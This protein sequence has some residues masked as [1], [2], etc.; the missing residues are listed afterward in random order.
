MSG[1]ITVTGGSATGGS[2]TGGSV[3]PNGATP[4]TAT[5]GTAT[6]GTIINGSGT[7]TPGT[8]TSGSGG[9]GVGGS[10]I[11]G[12]A[13]STPLVTP[14]TTPLVTP[15]TLLLP[16]TPK[17]IQTNLIS[18]GSVPAK[19]TDPN[20]INPWGVSFSA[21]SPFSVSDQ[22]TNFASLD[23]VTTSATGD[24]SVA[25]NVFPP[26]ATP[27]P[28]GQVFNS[29]PSAFALT[30]GQPATIL[31]A[32]TAGQIIGWNGGAQATIGVNNPNAVYTG[33]AI[34]MSASGPTLYAANARAGTVDMYDSSF[35]LIK[36]ISD[37]SIPPG[38]TPYGVQVLKNQLFVTYAPA[39]SRLNGAGQGMVDQFD[40]NGN[41]VGL[42]AAGNPLNAPWGLAIAPSSFGAFAGALLVGNFGDGTIS[43]FDYS[44]H[45]FLGQLN[46]T[47][48]Q[49]LVNQDLW[50]I[51][52]GNGGSAGDPYQ[53]YFTAGLMDERHGL[54]GSIKAA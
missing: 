21:T 13:T 19:V 39:N 14:Q 18:D 51:T 36:T 53:L 26:L 23:S 31:F 49:P 50:A 7:V 40:L 30:N 15:Q 2:A 24:N 38:F 28:T 46:G 44:T 35:K 37:P 22:G 48:G 4:G 27:S 20:L 54:F 47:D 34:G 10:A 42:V 8:A 52:P 32:S 25:L 29:F 12:N 16:S 1:T 33:L 17:F 43:A 3:G 9:A 5:A 45:A 6:A 41:R 11:G